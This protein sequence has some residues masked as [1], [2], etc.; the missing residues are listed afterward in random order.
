MTNLFAL[1]DGNGT[2]FYFVHVTLNL[3]F[4]Y[5]ALNS[6]NTG[7]LKIV[8]ILLRHPQINERICVYG[9]VGF[10]QEGV[11]SKLTVLDDHQLWPLILELKKFC[12]NEPSKGESRTS[13]SGTLAP[14]FAVTFQ[15]QSVSCVGKERRRLRPALLRT[16]PSLCQQGQFPF[17]ISPVLS[18][19]CVPQPSK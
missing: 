6:L 3:S 16:Y 9:S 15:L 8:C 13:F 17:Q 12:W 4:G 1:E 7:D 2:G 18:F 14:W 19:H 11:N 10:S 5:S